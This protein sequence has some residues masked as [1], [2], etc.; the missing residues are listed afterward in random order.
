MG[1]TFDHVHIKTEQCR[2]AAEWFVEHFGARILYER[3]QE[4]GRIV[5]VELCGVHINF[6]S[7]RTW[8]ELEPGSVDSRYGLEHI[9]IGTDDLEGV[10]SRLTAAGV[11]VLSPIRTT[12]RGS[13]MAFVRAPG[14]V[15][16]ELFSEPPD[17]PS[18]KRG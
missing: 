4:G 14:D 18:A 10:M 5:R 17:E 12:P 8:E 1:I 16:V 11:E 6:T 7:R 2:Q 13:K 3:E 9:G 15:R